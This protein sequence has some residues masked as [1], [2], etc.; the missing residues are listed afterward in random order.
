MQRLIVAERWD[1]ALRLC[2]KIE[3]EHHEFPEEQ[4]RI[5][6]RYVELDE[7]QLEKEGAFCLLGK[8]YW[9]G[10]RRTRTSIVESQR[11]FQRSAEAGSLLGKLCYAQSLL[12]FGPR[13]GYAAAEDMQLEAAAGGCRV[14][15]APAARILRSRGKFVEAARWYVR[16]GD[17]KSVEELRKGCTP[18]GVWH[19][20]L[21]L[22]VPERVHEQMLATMLL[23]KR[24][25]VPH[26]VALMIAEYV[27]TN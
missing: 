22:L 2:R 12:F 4:L 11:W 18:F 3:E 27:C 9:Y 25:K 8:L 23:C 19:A 26:G 5:V 6:L 10:G 7:Q 17:R 16:A 1:D 14:A 20:S 21:H 24:K 13:D 15:Y